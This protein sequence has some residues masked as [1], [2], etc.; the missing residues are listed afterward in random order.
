MLLIE[1]ALSRLVYQAYPSDSD[2]NDL[3]RETEKM[4]S[5]L[6]HIG[7]MPGHVILLLPHPDAAERGSDADLSECLVNQR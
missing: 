4:F 2:R 7:K 1:R 3:R 5:I 6:V